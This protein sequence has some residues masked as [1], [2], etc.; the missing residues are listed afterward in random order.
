VLPVLEVE[1]NNMALPTDT[2]PTTDM[3]LTAL[4]ERLR[5]TRHDQEA[6]HLDRLRQLIG[7][8]TETCPQCHRRSARRRSRVRRQAH[9]EVQEKIRHEAVAC[10]RAL[11]ERGYTQEESAALLDVPVRRLL[12]WEYKHRLAPLTLVPLGRPAAPAPVLA[13]QQVLAF[14]QEQGPGVG[15]PRLCATFPDLSRAVLTDLVQRYRAV[16]QVRYR[17]CER[18]LHWQQPGAVWA[19]DFAEPSR[20]GA[21]GVL[22]P[23][24]GELPYVLAVRDLASGY[25]LCWLPVTAATAAVTTA[26]LTQLFAKHGAPLVLKADNGPPFRAVE[27]KAFLESRDVQILFSPP[28]WPGYNGAIEAAIGSLK[29]RTEHHAAARA[30]A[31]FWT[32]A[33]L[34][35]ARQA[36]NAS[37]P[38]R[39]HGRTPAEVWAARTPLSAVERV[40]FE[41][42][43]QRER[44]TASN[45][46]GLDP[47][48]SGDHWQQARLDRKA[49]E[50]ALV[51]R[52][53]LLFKGRRVPL[54]IKP[55]KMTT[56]V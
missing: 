10:Y 50:R 55:G 41:L 42:A 37:H 48:D 7:N 32:P 43:V 18:V 17:T 39:L 40:C 31:G 4:L 47:T 30:Q 20:W 56:F 27:T 54:T 49:I 24:A 19:V 22:P 3:T 12:D 23:V 15:V 11:D 28:Y 14:L 51:G 6:E 21:A 34:E 35:A 25:Q 9:R 46:L 16:V 29:R 45:E 33:D 38:R 26:V 44:F 2:E 8:P 5:V 53:Y 52:D 1:N 36:A 13:R